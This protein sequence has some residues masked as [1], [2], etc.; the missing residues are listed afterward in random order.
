MARINTPGGVIEIPDSDPR[1]QAHRALRIAAERMGANEYKARG[2]YLGFR[3]SQAMLDVIKAMPLVLKGDITPDEAM[4][5]LQRGD[6]L[7]SRLG[8]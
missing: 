7:E 3:P 4:N 5:L 1:I 8:K 2:K 6:V